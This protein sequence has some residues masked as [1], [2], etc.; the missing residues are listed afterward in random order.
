MQALLGDPRTLLTAAEVTEALS[1]KRGAQ[2]R[3]GVEVLTS[4]DILTDE[5][6]KVQARGGSVTWGYRAPDRVAGQ[7][8]QVSAV[9]RRAS[10]TVSGTADLVGKRLRLWTEWKLKEA[11]SYA[12][13][14][15]ESGPVGFWQFEETSGTTAVDTVGTR[16]ATWTGAVELGRPGASAGSRAALLRGSDTMYGRTSATL[17]SSAS[18]LSAECWVNFASGRTQQAMMEQAP[19]DNTNGDW[20]LYV[21]AGVGAKITFRV[22]NDASGLVNASDPADNRQGTGWHHVVGTLGAGTMR[23]YVD[24]VQ[25]A[26]AAVTRT[27]AKSAGNLWF[28]RL[29]SATSYALDG[30]LDD[31]A[32]Y[33]RELSAAEVAEHYRLGSAKD[34]WARFYLGVY[35]VTNPGAI[36]DDGLVVQRRLELAGKSYLWASTTL[37]DPVHV[38]A[39]TNLF[40]FI[41]TDMGTRFGETTFNFPSDTVTIAQPRTFETGTS[42]LAM[43]S[44]LLETGGYDQLHDDELGKPRTVRLNELANRTAETTYGPSLGKIVDPG[45]LDPLLPSIPNVLRFS[46]RQGPS[47]GNTNGNGLTYRRNQN[48]GPA[49]ISRRGFEVEMVIDVDAD[50]QAELEAVANTDAQRYFAGGGERFNGRVGLNPLHSDRDVIGLERPRL[51]VTG[52]LW[53]VTEWTYPLGPIEA[54][55]DVLMDIIAERRVTIS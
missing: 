34:R 4:R 21:E 48:T 31:A 50:S 36:T 22:T 3:H 12:Q 49:S 10:I 26:S 13:V 54:D 28:G 5:K 20:L 27:V 8:S 30:S 51:A 55:S 45:E 16:P 15:Q 47:I 25:V 52:A 1:L 7:S 38:A 2:V 33:N 6:L 44:A 9:R 24:G 41:K 43:Y 17:P 35:I 37:K 14:I 29:A 19:G 39:G 11:K 18:A 42:P 32:V 23:L 53:N 46:A 40:T